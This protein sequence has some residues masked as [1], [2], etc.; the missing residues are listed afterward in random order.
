M[1]RLSIQHS[2]LCLPCIIASPPCCAPQVLASQDA[3]G[4][5]VVRQQLLGPRDKPLLY[6]KHMAKHRIGVP[7]ELLRRARHVLLVREPA[8]VIHSFS[9]VCGLAPPGGNLKPHRPPPRSLRISWA[10][11]C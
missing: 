2:T 8:A 11:S 10:H 6:A 1:V 5:R 7:R 9:E 3:D 4:G